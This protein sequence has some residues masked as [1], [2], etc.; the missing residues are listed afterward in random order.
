MVATEEH[1]EQYVHSAATLDMENSCRAYTDELRPTVVPSALD[2]PQPPAKREGFHVAIICAMPYEADT[3]TLLF[4]Q[5]WDDDGDPYGQAAGDANTYIT[6]RIGN[7][8][9]VLVVLSDSGVSN[10]AIAT[11][12]LQLSYTGIKLAFLVGVCG[13]VPRIADQDVMLGDVVV[14]STIVHCGHYGHTLTHL[15]DRS[16]D[17]DTLKNAN[18]EVRCLFTTLGTELMR[19]RLQMHSEKHLTHLQKVAKTGQWR[20]DYLYPGI[21]EDNLYPPAHGHKHQALCHVCVGESGGVCG[22]ATQASCVELGCNLISPIERQQQHDRGL[23]YKP[24]IFFGKIGS[25]TTMECG[26][27]R[28]RISDHHKLIAFETEAAGLY[29]KIPCI[30]VKGICDYADGHKQK[31]WQDFAAATAAS[32]M[33]AMLGRYVPR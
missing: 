10:A 23:R 4:D 11:V 31:R 29:E 3:V 14:S 21:N 24:K 2:I 12:N 13:A 9:V 8:N 20:A 19:N 28:D 32:V 33:R 18:S 1:S 30:V 7:H 15:G 22:S 16:T 5:F 26:M 17:N 6:G 25:G 27:K